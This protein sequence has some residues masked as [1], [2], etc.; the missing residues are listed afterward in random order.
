MKKNHKVMFGSWLTQPDY[1]LT[2]IMA[3]SGY[4]SW[5]AV[6]LE[7]TVID[8]S[9][10]ENMVRI[11]RLYN[12]DAYVRIAENSAMLIKRVLDAGANGIIVPMVN[13]AEDAA[14]AM[15]ATFYPPGG[16]RGVGLGRAQGYGVNFR[17]Y[18]DK[19]Q[20]KTKVIVQIEHIEAVRNIEEIFST[21]GIFGYYVGPYDLSASL[22]KAG[23]FKCKEMLEALKIVK[24]AGRKYGL[25]GGFH[26]IEPNPDEIKGKIK[27]GYTIICVSL[28]MLILSRAVKSIF[29]KVLWR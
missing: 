17:K 26:V 23:D 8:M 24:E 13:T 2:E 22:G 3:K 20:Y 9:Q 29:S 11:I 27:E 5:L 6:D 14:K 4:F 21:K 10:V 28:D 18:C 15:E 19:I 16:S 12:L 25:R 1:A 7:H